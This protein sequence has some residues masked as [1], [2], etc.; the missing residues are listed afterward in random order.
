VTLL[1]SLSYGVFIVLKEGLGKELKEE[2]PHL[3]IVPREGSPAGV[4]IYKC[5]KEKGEVGRYCGM[6]AGCNSVPSLPQGPPSL[7]PSTSGNNLPSGSPI[8]P[9]S[10]IGSH[11]G[12]K[13]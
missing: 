13:L 11:R 2:I 3:K 6:Q 4:Y 10:L 5:V 7:P 12:I 9:Q 8:M 1:I